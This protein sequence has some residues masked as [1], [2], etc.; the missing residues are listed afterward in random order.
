MSSWQRINDNVLPPRAKAGANYIN[1]RYAFLQARSD[2]YDLPI[3]LGNDGKVSESSGACIFMI[4][5]KKLITPPVTAS[6]L[7]SI[8]RGIIM[9]IAID[10]NFEVEERVIDRTELYLAEEIFLCG[11]AAE[12]TP[13][14]KIDRFL[15]NDGKNGTITLKLLEEYINVCT[16][17]NEQY[18]DCILAIGELN[19]L[20]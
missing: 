18:R 6:I 1:G 9:E 10:L 3:F 2:G 13:I 15:L 4:T 19:E 12:I 20:K 17:T 16:G 11:T 8:T 5:G 7:E 14:T